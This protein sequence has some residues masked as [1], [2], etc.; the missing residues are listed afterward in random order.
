MAG[1]IGWCSP[2]G[3]SSSV[4]VVHQRAFTVREAVR[5]AVSEA[6]PGTD[7]TPLLPPS[8]TNTATMHSITTDTAVTAAL[9]SPASSIALLMQ[10]TKRESKSEGNGRLRTVLLLLLLLL[11]VAAAAVVVLQV[12]LQGTR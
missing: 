4:Q 2:F 8:P 11:L 12:L 6:P 3:Y 1:E 9:V 7:P 10:R 5:E